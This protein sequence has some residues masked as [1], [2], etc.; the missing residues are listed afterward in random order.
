L[1]A[2]QRNG[3]PNERELFHFCPE[4]VIAKIWQEVTGARG[5]VLVP[6]ATVRL[7]LPV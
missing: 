4:S 1:R 2:Q 6:C 3:N 5:R 7:T